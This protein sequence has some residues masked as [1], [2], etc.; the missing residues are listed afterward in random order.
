LFHGGPVSVEIVAHVVPSAE[1][2]KVTDARPE[3]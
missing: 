3:A 1:Y 2:W